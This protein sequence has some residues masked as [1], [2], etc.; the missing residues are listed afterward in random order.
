MR[1]VLGRLALVVLTCVGVLWPWLVSRIPPLGTAPPTD[2]VVITDYR[3]TFTVAA[4]GE[5]VAQEDITA[6]FPSGR[7]GIFRYWDVADPADPGV[8][9]VPTITGINQDGVPAT[10]QTSWESQR[11]YL[12]AKIGDPDAYL[13]RGE[14]RYTIQYAIPGAISPA[15]SGQGATFGSQ[16]GTDDG[17]PGSVL[18]WNVVAQGWE[19]QIRRATITL[20]LPARSGVVQ[21]SAG[22]A[23]GPCAIRGAGSTEVVLTAADLPPRS[24]MT[25]RVTMAPPAPAR[26]RLPWS[27]GWDAVLGR[28]V[29]GVALVAVGSALGLVAGIAWSRLAREEPPGFPVQYAPPEGLGPVQVVFMDTEGTG[30]DALTATLLHLAERGLVALDRT[31]ADRWTISGIASPQQWEAVDPVGQAVADRL[32]LRTGTFSASRSSVSS[33]RRLKQARDA[34]G[35]TAT[36]WAQ[37]SGLVRAAPSE[38]AGRLAWGAA[39]ALAV[40]GFT[41]LLTPTM[42]GLPFAAFAVGATGLLATGVGRRRTMAGRVVWSRSGGFERLLSTPS[43]GDRFDFAARQDL[44]IAYIPYAVAFGVADRW[45]DKYRMATGAEPPVPVW[46]PTYAGSS[47]SVYS[48]GGRDS[49]ASTVAASISAY[50]ASQSSSSGRGGGGGGFGGG[51]GGGGGGSW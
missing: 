39:V 6:E 31:S 20:Q 30:P 48:S 51:G 11:R 49:F 44:F 7:H 17:P 38:T 3:A 33:G 5:L 36:R 15:S 32:G 47:S 46:Y 26:T 50:S 13:S 19:M 40:L 23:T 2:P 18:F 28:S 37:Q 14:H 10:Y 27:V 43:A 12:V 29:G 25:A 9:Y 45:A 4:D 21:C 42:W 1:V 34:I 41:G 35:G 16:E 24:G 22:W 8:R